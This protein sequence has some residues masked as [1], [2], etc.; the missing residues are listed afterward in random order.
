MFDSAPLA[1]LCETLT[2]STK[3]EADIQIDR[4]TYTQTRRS[5]YFTPLL[6]AKSLAYLSKAIVD[7]KLRPRCAVPPLS[8]PISHIA[9]AQKFFEYYLCLPGILNDLVCSERDSDATA[10]VAVKIADTFEWP[11]QPPKIAHPHLSHGSVGPPEPLSKT[12]MSIGSAVF[13]QRTV[14]CPITLQWAAASPFPKKL[15]PSLGRSGP[16][17]N[18]WYLQPTRV[19]NPNGILIGSA[20]F[21]WVSNAMLYNGNENPQNCQFSLEFRHP[22]RE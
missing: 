20:V 22:A 16:P 12:G 7:I 1:P 10:T 3:P 11:G 6:W 21:V 4:Q 19:I 8:W 18:T 14:E 15:A 2:S 9:C 5:Q 13:A 17:S